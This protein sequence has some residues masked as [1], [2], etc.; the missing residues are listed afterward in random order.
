MP[1]QIGFIGLGNPCSACSATR[2][3]TALATAREHL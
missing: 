3:L 2:F 1:E